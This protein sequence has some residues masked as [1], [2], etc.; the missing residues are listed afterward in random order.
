VSRTSGIQVDVVAERAPEELPENLPE[1]HRT[2]VYRVVQEAVH[3]ASRHSA[4]HHIRIYLQQTAE[5]RLRVSVQDDG[6]G[7]EPFGDTGLGILGMEE[8][9]LR[10]GGTMNL[11]SQ[12]G[13]GTIISFELPV[14]GQIDAGQV[15]RPLRTA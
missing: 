11:D 14:P 4:A 12:P 5:G 10:L 2:C 13:R 7:F 9:I 15:T 1:E 3:N 6:K 8:R